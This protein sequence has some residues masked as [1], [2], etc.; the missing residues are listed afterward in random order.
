MNRLSGREPSPEAVAL[1][2]L[3]HSKS[4]GPSGSNGQPSA[5]AAPPPPPLMLPPADPRERL[6]LLVNSL[7][8]TESVEEE[9]GKICQGF[10][11]ARSGE[12]KGTLEKLI[13]EYREKC[14]KAALQD[15]Q[16][17]VSDLYQEYRG[18]KEELIATEKILCQEEVNTGLDAI[19]ERYLVRLLFV[20]SKTVAKPVNIDALLYSTLPELEGRDLNH[21]RYCDQRFYINNC[22]LFAL[23]DHRF[24]INPVQKPTTAPPCNMTVFEQYT[25]P[26]FDQTE[27]QETVAKSLTKL[28]EYKEHP[29]FGDL[30][31]V[32]L[33]YFHLSKLHG[34]A[35]KPTVAIPFLRSFL[36]RTDFPHQDLLLSILLCAMERNWGLYSAADQK[37]L[38]AWAEVL[39][40]LKE[41]EENP[42]IFTKSYLAL[43]N[44]RNKNW[45]AAMHYSRLCAANDQGGLII[46][47][48]RELIKHNERQKA[49]EILPE[50]LPFKD[51]EAFIMM[52]LLTESTDLIQAAGFYKE[53][54]KNGG[55]AAHE[56]LNRILPH[57]P[58]DRELKRVMREVKPEADPKVTE[59][60]ALFPRPSRS[61]SQEE[62]G[63]KTYFETLFRSTAPLLQGEFLESFRKAQEELKQRTAHELEVL[64]GKERENGEPSNTWT[65]GKEELFKKAE[66]AQDELKSSLVK[67]QAER[68][69]KKVLE[70]KI[71]GYS[72]QHL[73]RLEK[74]RAYWSEGLPH[75]GELEG[76]KAA[77][78]E[79]KNQIG[80]EAELEALKGEQ[81]KALA[82][83]SDPQRKVQE[84][85][86]EILKLKKQL[87]EMQESQRVLTRQ[88][89]EKDL[90]LEEQ[91]REYTLLENWQQ[92]LALVE[93]QSQEEDLNGLEP[94][95][96]HRIYN[97]PKIAKKEEMI[98]LLLFCGF[99]SST[100]RGSHQYF[101]KECGDKKIFCLIYSHTAELSR[102]ERR[103]CLQRIL[104]SFK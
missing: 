61:W 17:Q 49:K 3:Y 84:K 14:D 26:L 81:D 48:S 100:T 15:S 31:G 65:S 20:L 99:K 10:K 6:I 89:K 64:I 58:Q 80:S 98:S 87:A 51:A 96:Y 8:K 29:Q 35:C 38:D 1:M 28:E 101:V 52:G 74:M 53:A 78:L 67:Q 55:N 93:E 60:V 69:K 102:A 68:E 32:T 75:I 73:E 46:V 21:Y 56:A 90:Q 44:K 47:L 57:I 76:I 40:L 71:E 95:L 43:K 70:Q 104:L 86:E 5:P 41:L 83:F 62:K 50:A 7:F 16:Q 11:V 97:L 88:L 94:K 23:I 22:L 12:I 13:K 59:L 77:F 39:D 72:R 9:Y 34:T 103:L 25:Q 33:A 42:S 24:P 18:K 36:A 30:I 2:A 63:A 27:S 54:L 45:P 66:K 82:P 37:E 19:K 4:G 91:E 85:E 79:K 92:S